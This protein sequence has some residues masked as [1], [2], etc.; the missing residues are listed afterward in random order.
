MQEEV[1]QR[2]QNIA[3]NISVSNAGGVP[4]GNPNAPPPSLQRGVLQVTPKVTGQN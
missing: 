4:A 3:D 1:I 2:Q